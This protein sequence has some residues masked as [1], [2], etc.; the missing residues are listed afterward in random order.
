MI[1]E[2]ISDFANH[3]SGIY[4]L[5]NSGLEGGHAMRIVSWGVESENKYWK[6]SAGLGLLWIWSA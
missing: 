6:V 5:V 3:V 1:F 2:H 4:H